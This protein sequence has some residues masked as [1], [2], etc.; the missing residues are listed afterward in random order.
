MFFSVN[1][2]IKIGERTFRPC[3][4]YKV[5]P[6]LELTINK[7]A[8]EGKVTLHEKQIFFCNGKIVENKPAVKETLT[9]EKP[10][11]EKKAK[12]APVE[13]I[14]S[15]EEIADNPDEVEGF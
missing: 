11:K 14:P 1:N 13:D 4:C 6:Y 5:T 10:K 9:E 2:S 3:I 12:T 7:L 8:K 15:P